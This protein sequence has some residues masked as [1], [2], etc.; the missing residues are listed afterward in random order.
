M[1]KL[2]L[3]KYFTTRPRSDGS[4]RYFW[5]PGKSLQAKGFAL[6]RL[7][8]NL[9][10]AIEQAK[11]ENE[12]AE[13]IL[14]AGGEISAE[15][16]RRRG[17]VHPDSVEAMVRAYQKS[18]DYL[19]KAEKTRTEYDAAIAHLL[20]FCG[21]QPKRNIT[22]AIARDFF[23]ALKLKVTIDPQT[24]ARIETPRPSVAAAVCRVARLIWYFDRGADKRPK[25][26]LE[27][28]QNPFAF[29]RLDS[30][31]QVE[32]D[33]ELDLW[34][35]EAIDA[36]VAAADVL[37]LPSVGDAILLNSWIGQ[38][39]ADCLAV[40]RT[41]LQGDCLKIRTRKRGRWVLLPVADVPALYARMAAAIARLEHWK[42]DA[43][44]VIV[45]ESTGLPYST[46]HFAAKFEAVRNDVAGRHPAWAKLQFAKLRH[47]A[48]VRLSEAEVDDLQISA[49]TGHKA[50]TVKSIIERYHVKTRKMAA[51][52]FRKRLAAEGGK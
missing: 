1:A 17:S 29:M 2:D 27:I 4:A 50:E 26:A 15:P 51:T 16:K 41:L 36:F 38:R 49:V 30:Q 7:A 45:S 40:P 44:T 21:D 28:A 39:M 48:V 13:R 42:V 35:P 34:S 10:T 3:P 19:G 18:D 11:A 32:L 46:D 37:D 12:T 31:R 23:N 25:T 8:D 47:T 43:T 9:A 24:K 22:P 6:K 52:A 20:G 33:P 5:Q 14:A